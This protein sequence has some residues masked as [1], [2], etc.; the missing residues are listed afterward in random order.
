VKARQVKIG[1]YTSETP[2]QVFL[3]KEISGVQRNCFGSPGVPVSEGYRAELPTCW[4]NLYLP[5]PS[6]KQNDPV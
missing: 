3:E 6:L 1:F 2:F 5:D 4:N